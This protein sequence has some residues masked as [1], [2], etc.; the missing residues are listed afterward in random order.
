MIS[1]LEGTVSGERKKLLKNEPSPQ[2][3]GCC[4][5]DYDTFNVSHELGSP[6]TCT[7]IRN[8]KYIL[9]NPLIER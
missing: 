9:D 2:L 3:G 6:N 1:K 7:M 4:I 5:V 8:S